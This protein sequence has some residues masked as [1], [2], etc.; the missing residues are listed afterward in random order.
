MEWVGD[1]KRGAEHKFMLD[2]NSSALGTVS[3][4]QYATR[5]SDLLR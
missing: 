5:V 2:D 4:C 1:D 3:I